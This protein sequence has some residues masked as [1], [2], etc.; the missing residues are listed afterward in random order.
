MKR[1]RFERL[2]TSRDPVVAYVA[3]NYTSFRLLLNTVRQPLKIGQTTVSSRDDIARAWRSELYLTSDGQGLQ[4][5]NT[6]PCVHGWVN[7]GTRLLSGAGYIHA[8][9]V[10]GNL[11]YTNLRASKGRRQRDTRCEKCGR[12]EALGHILQVCPDSHDSRI[13]RHNKLLKFVEEKAADRGYQCVIEPAIPTT[14]GI[15]RPDLICHKGDRALV[16]DVTVVADNARLSQAHRDKVA[17]YSVPA[18]REHVANLAS[19]PCNDVEFS[20]VSLNW[21]GALSRESE[22]T[23]RSLGFTSRDLEV[24]SV[25]TLE[26]GY[27]TYRSSRRSTWRGRRRP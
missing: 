25:R 3:G 11:L 15:R 14:A 19:I 8:L 12:V 24:L 20:S 10:R 4:S 16:I 17:Y 18:I 1:S 2:V 9:H 6:V 26:G 21:R 5:S 27:N 13:T 7:S 22:A 23:L